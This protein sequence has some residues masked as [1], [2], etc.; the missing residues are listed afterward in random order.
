MAWTKANPTGKCPSIYEAMSL[1]S[2]STVYT[3]VINNIN[4]I[5]K[6]DKA[7]KYLT[8]VVDPSST[9]ASGNFETILYGAE[10]AGG[11][12]FLLKDAVVADFNTADATAG[13]ID[14]SAYP[15]PYYYIGIKSAGNDSAKTAKVYVYGD[16]D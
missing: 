12:K 2:A 15:A 13:Q 10:K 16:L 5:P 7:N 1:G 14:I 9:P 6:H 3:S 4:P 11:T 8:V